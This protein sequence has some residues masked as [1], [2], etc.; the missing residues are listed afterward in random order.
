MRAPRSPDRTQ[1]TAGA[2]SHPRPDRTYFDAVVMRTG[3][4]TVL[5]CLA[6]VL[7]IV[8]VV[9]PPGDEP[10]CEPVGRQ[11]LRVGG[12]HQRCPPGYALRGPTRGNGLMAVAAVA[13]PTHALR[14][15]LG[16]HLRW[17]S[18]GILCDLLL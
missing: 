13:P 14:V 18:L 4:Q 8:P 15:V 12:L 5:H 2:I 11:R 9:A 7:I 10:H 17:M 3:R 1:T 6:L 16:N